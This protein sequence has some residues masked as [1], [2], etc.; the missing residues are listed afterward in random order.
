[1][2]L[3]H[4]SKCTCLLHTSVFSS[5]CFTS[6]V[7]QLPDLQAMEEETFVFLAPGVSISRSWRG[8]W[9][10]LRSAHVSP[11]SP[12][13]DSF[14]GRV[15]LVASRRTRSPDGQRHMK[16]CSTLLKKKLREEAG[17]WQEST[18]LRVS[19]R[20]VALLLSCY[21]TRFIAITSLNFARPELRQV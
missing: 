20:K 15:L 16:G 2:F 11:P 10:G 4:F 3:N 12:W 21:V 13:I 8:L 18:G 14:L 1:M 5:Y 7:L 19:R 6:A 17:T 9:T